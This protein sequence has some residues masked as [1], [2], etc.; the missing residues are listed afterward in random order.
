[1]IRLSALIWITFRFLCLFGCYMKTLY[2]S[3]GGGVC[4]SACA[5]ICLCLFVFPEVVNPPIK[6]LMK[7]YLEMSASLGKHWKVITVGDTVEIINRILDLGIVVTVLTVAKTSLGDTVTLL[8]V[9]DY[10]FVTSGYRLLLIW[11]YVQFLFWVNFIVFFF[12][13]LVNI[14]AKLEKNNID[15]FFL[16]TIHW[17]SFLFILFEIIYI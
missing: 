5:H 15:F 4:V 10:V 13:H 2:F 16:F 3:R 8:A 12:S 1:M 6:S 7:S 14:D 9:V 11:A 17:M